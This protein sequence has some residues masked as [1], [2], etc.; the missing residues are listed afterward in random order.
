MTRALLASVRSAATS[1]ALGVFVVACSSEPDGVVDAGTGHDASFDVSSNFD[2]ATLPPVKLDVVRNGSGTVT[3]LP[4]GIDCGATCSATLA[5]GSTV[6][7]K[8]VAANGF[9]FTGWS[10]AATCTGTG[11][12]AVTLGA[13]TTITANFIQPK[14]QLTVTTSGSGSVTSS[15]AGISCAPT[16]S[17]SFDTGTK[18]TLNPTPAAGWVFTGWGGACSGNGPCTPTLNAPTIV[19]ATFAPNFTTWDPSWSIPG[20]AYSNGNRTISGNSGGSKNVRTLIGKSSGK[21]YWEIATIGGDGSSDAGGI[22]ILEAGMPNNVSYIGI[23]PS[24]LAFGYGSCCYAQYWLSWSG[25]STFGVPPAGSAIKTGNTYMFALD[26]DLKRVWFGHN[27]V[28]YNGGNPGA[29]VN[30]AASNLSG[31]VYPGVTFYS[32]SINAFTANFGQQGFAYP[33]PSGFNPGLY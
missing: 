28:W 20:V 3:S 25:V 30:P 11:S 27:G 23:S 14:T 33:V 16:C 1:I 32:A 8:A 6:V 29:N 21:W 12:C 5:G 18:V 4:A 19:S 7:L 9:T 15:P 24:G 13:D 10:G 26:M 31:T 22:G 2:V 17:A